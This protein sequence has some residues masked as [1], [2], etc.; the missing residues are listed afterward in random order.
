[1]VNALG[2]DRSGSWRK[3][4][5]RAALIAGM[6][7]VAWPAAAQTSSL[8]NAAHTC[9]NQSIK[10]AAERIEACTRLLNSGR[11]HGK[12]LGVA[13]ALRGLAYLDRGDLPNAIIDLNLAVENAP[14]FVPAYQNRGNAHYAQGNLKGALADYNRAIKLD[15]GAASAYV[16]RA[17]VRSDLG[18]TDEALADFAKAIELTPRNAGAYRGRGA[19][20][21]RQKRYELALA[22]SKRAVELAP[23]R[24]NRRVREKANAAQRKAKVATREDGHGTSSP[25]H[26]RGK[27]VPRS[28]AKP[29]RY[30]HRQR[31]RHERKALARRDSFGIPSSSIWIDEYGRPLSAREI[32]EVQWLLRHSRPMPDYPTYSYYPYYR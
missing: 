6:I 17:L 19:L 1:M 22:D 3:R 28:K 8:R 12:P 21:L 14:D 26:E 7:V 18:K 32:G 4:P 16:N 5:F 13:Y 25:P 11:L 31:E 29:P 24:E 2:E 27:A 20:Y 23:T 10:L 30:A 9:A 15:P